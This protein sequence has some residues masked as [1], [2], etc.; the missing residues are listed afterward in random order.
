ML[1]MLMVTDAED[2]NTMMVNGSE[3]NIIPAMKFFFTG[4]VLKWV[5]ADID[6]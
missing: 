6:A 2:P 4:F 3:G 5:L 1:L